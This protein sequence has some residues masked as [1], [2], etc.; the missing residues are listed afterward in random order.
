[1]SVQKN[2][3]PFFP[4]KAFHLFQTERP[5]LVIFVSHPMQVSIDF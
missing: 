4:L 2:G 3:K 1:M 5:F